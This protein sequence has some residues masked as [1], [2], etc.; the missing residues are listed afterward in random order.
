M[1]VLQGRVDGIFWSVDKKEH[2]Q[3]VTGHK[4]FQNSSSKEV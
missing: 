2:I 4:Q 1:A 3:E